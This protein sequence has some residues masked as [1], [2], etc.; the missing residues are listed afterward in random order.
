MNAGRALMVKHLLHPR[1]ARG[2]KSVLFFENEV[3]VFSVISPNPFHSC[4]SS[5][6]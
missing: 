2:K 6:L 5:I 3:I 1:N 4:Y